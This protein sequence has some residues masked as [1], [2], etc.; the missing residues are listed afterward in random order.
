MAEKTKPDFG[1]WLKSHTLY[2]PGDNWPEAWLLQKANKCL[3]PLAK[4]VNSDAD[5]LS[6]YIEYGLQAGKHNE[7]HEVA[8]HLGLER[9]ECL[10]IFTLVVAQQFAAEF[11][12]V[13]ERIRAILDGDD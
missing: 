10:Q 9:A 3:Q 8:R 12:H 4:L 13:A 1:N 11:G 7:F 5:D 2:L 6:E